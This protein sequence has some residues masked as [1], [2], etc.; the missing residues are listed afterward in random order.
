MT[1]KN[2]FS[3]KNILIQTKKK[4]FRI[5]AVLVRSDLKKALLNNKSRARKVPERAIFETHK[6]IERNFK[7]VSSSGEVDEAWIIDNTTLPSYKEF[8]TSK[9]IK[10]VK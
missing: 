1:G 7:F 8:R 6:E 3:L 2:I 4:G 5:I 9:F 10:K